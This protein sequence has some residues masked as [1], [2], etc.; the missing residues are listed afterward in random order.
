[1]DSEVIRRRTDRQNGDHICLTFLCNESRLK[2]GEDRN[3][4]PV[5]VRRIQNDGRKFSEDT[6]KYIR[7]EIKFIC[8]SKY[9]NKLKLA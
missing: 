5:S 4:R 3:A 2:H 1:M 7:R 9:Q 8:T 6:T